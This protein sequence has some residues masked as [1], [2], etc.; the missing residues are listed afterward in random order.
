VNE[1]D[2]VLRAEGAAD[3]GGRIVVAVDCSAGSEAALRFAVEDA[4][5]R[6]VPVDA[7]MAYL[8]P[9][10]WSEFNVVG[11]GDFEQMRARLHRETEDRLRAFVERVVAEVAGPPAEVR[12]R[13]VLG[14]T[15]DVLLRESHGADLLVVGSRGH[16]GFS[17]V[18]LG[19]T[20]M[21]L[22]LHATCP[23]TVVHSPEA[24]RHR[25]GLHRER[26]S[27]HRLPVN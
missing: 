22:A 21:Q 9:D 15:A 11:T 2:G 8:T 5:R 17:S 24:H 3:A 1:D 4:A 25:L 19:S 12:P 7:V 26:R 14:S 27:G 10:Y 18:L 13:A 16:G 23:V 20:S 6:G